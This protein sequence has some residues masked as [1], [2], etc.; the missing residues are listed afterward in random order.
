[1]VSGLLVNDGNR[2]WWHIRSI[3]GFSTSTIPV[4]GLVII[5]ACKIVVVE[6]LFDVSY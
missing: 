3:L 4:V 5:S 2:G 1:V 6:L